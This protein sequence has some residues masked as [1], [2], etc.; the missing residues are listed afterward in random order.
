[1]TFSKI[2]AISALAL[3]TF[4]IVGCDG[5]PV[6]EFSGNGKGQVNG[7]NTSGFG[8]NNNN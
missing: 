8:G 5:R 1:M 2:M 3:F 4:S 6:L 7:P